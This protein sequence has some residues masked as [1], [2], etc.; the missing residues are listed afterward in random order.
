MKYIKKILA[1]APTFFVGC[2]A[3]YA[4]EKNDVDIMHPQRIQ[5]LHYNIQHF[6]MTHLTEENVKILKANVIGIND[7]DIEEAWNNRKTESVLLVKLNATVKSDFYDLNCYFKVLNLASLLTTN[8]VCV[9]WHNKTNSLILNLITV[10]LDKIKDTLDN[11]IKVGN[12]LNPTVIKSYFFKGIG[13]SKDMNTWTEEKYD[14][15][16]T[17]KDILLERIENPIKH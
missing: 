9:Q 4:S 5:A 16:M 3:L 6:N 10:D 13:K 2:N 14:H 1:I 12:F 15:F 17:Y 8:Q 7:S 11:L